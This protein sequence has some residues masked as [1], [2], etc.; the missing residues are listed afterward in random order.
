MAFLKDETA[1]IVEYVA[2]M[3]DEPGCEGPVDDPVVI[4]EGQ[5]QH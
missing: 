2:K 3:P 5:R 4:R 1:R